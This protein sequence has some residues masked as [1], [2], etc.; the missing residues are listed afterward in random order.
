MTEGTAKNGRVEIA[1]QTIGAGGGAPLLLVMGTGGQMLNWPD[2]FCHELVDCGFTVARFDN[3]DSGL[4]TR[5]SE[6]GRPNQLRMWLRPGSAAVYR[7]EDMA[8]DAVAVLDDL[9]WPAAHIVGFSQGG[10][11]AQTIT[12]RYPDRALSLTSI[13]STPA[14]RLGQPT[15]ATLVKLAKV[16]NPKRVKDRDDFAQYQLDMHEAVGSPG[17]PLDPA[18]EERLREL[19]RLAY[20]R[21]G[22][23]MA[24]VQR[25]T[26]A[27][28]ASGDRRA[29][30]AKLRLPALVLHGGAD[31]VIRSVA[32]KA[33]A[34]AI[35][36]ARYVEYAG[37]GHEIPPG[38]FTSIADEIQA[39]A[40]ES[41]AE[42]SRRRPSG[43]PAPP[44]S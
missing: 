2:K 18:E 30:L 32:G 22:L 44:E 36:N 25:Q 28:V 16:V 7:L 20:D 37:M 4:S 21:G 3:R 31:R 39:V 26:A 8:A 42:L 13:S 34:D 27:I 14:P 9:G 29:E 41:A 38:L 1:Y 24:A 12:S 11:I 35:P 43:A 40:S 23:D 10:M 15:P 17:Y 6:Y 19:G 33:T 5:F